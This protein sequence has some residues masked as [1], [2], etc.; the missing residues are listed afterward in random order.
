MS[1]RSA[2]PSSKRSAGS[3][4]FSRTSS[5]APNSRT[6]LGALNLWEFASEVMSSEELRNKLNKIYPEGSAP[7]PGPVVEKADRRVGIR[8]RGSEV[9]GYLD[10]AMRNVINVAGHPAGSSKVAALTRNFVAPLARQA[11]TSADTSIPQ[12]P[13]AMKKIPWQKGRGT[14]IWAVASMTW[15]PNT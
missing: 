14:W 7:Q 4:R 12:V 6:S 15:E 10:E 13:A 5:I 9:G 2:K 1:R 11:L 3:R 8:R